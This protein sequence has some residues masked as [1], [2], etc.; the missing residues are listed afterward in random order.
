MWW[1]FE[2]KREEEKGERVMYLVLPD[3]P[4]VT[5]DN[6]QATSAWF[7][8]PNSGAEGH[9]FYERPT[10]FPPDTPWI[11]EAEAEKIQQRFAI[12]PQQLPRSSEQA[13]VS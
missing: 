6:Y 2:R 9:T 13:L 10:S 7:I 11:R 3:D 4:S 12:Q 5:I 8:D 1:P